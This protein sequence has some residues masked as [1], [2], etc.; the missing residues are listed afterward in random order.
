MSFFATREMA[1]AYAEARPPLHA[2]MVAEALDG[3]APVAWALDLG[4]GSGLSTRALLPFAARVTGIEPV[5]EM[6]EVARDLVP[7]AGFRVGGVEALPFAD[8]LCPLMAAAG[9]LNYCEVARGFAEIQRV[10]APGGMLLVYDFSV[11]LAP[12][13]TEWFAA[14]RAKYPAPPAG[15]RTEFDP[16]SLR[17]YM[18]LLRSRQGDWKLRVDA[19]FFL[20]YMLSETNVSMAVAN[21]ETLETIR[22]WCRPGI[23]AAFGG[24]ELELA[25]PGYFA[26]LG[27][28][29]G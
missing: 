24:G 1:R 21:G 5:A 6:V 14:F 10:L 27:H 4:S 22:E 28:A 20:R 3:F 19:A 26:L 13:L 25:F 9:S 2:R 15:S 7:E 18:P 11:G 12:E 16:G 23:E 17:R 29:G 8:G